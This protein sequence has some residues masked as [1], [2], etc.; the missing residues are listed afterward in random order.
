MAR[1]GSYCERSVTDIIL[2]AFF[3]FL[4]FNHKLFQASGATDCVLAFDQTYVRKS[5]KRRPM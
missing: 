2:L 3:D 1:Y 5:G 4:D